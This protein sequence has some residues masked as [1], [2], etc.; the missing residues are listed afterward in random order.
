VDVIAAPL[1]VLPQIGREVETA[2]QNW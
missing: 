1:P 2:Q